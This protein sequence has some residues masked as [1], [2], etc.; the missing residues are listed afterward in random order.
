MWHMV[1]SMW[2]KGECEGST[3]WWF[4]NLTNVSWLSRCMSCTWL[5]SRTLYLL[6]TSNRIFCMSSGDL[7]F[8]KLRSY[9]LSEAQLVEHGYPRADFEKPGHAVIHWAGYDKPPENKGRCLHHSRHGCGGQSEV[10]MLTLHHTLLLIPDCYAV[11]VT[12]NYI[13]GACMNPFSLL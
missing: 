7:L 11:C 6:Q 2:I 8:K 9:V 10:V 3:T 13:T 5:H 12:T 1:C 4:I